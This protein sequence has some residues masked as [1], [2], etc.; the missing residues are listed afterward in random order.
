MSIVQDPEL[1][2]EIASYIR[3]IPDHPK[4]GVRFRDVSTLAGDPNGLKLAIDGICAAFSTDR[5]QRVAG[6]E[7]RGF[8][9]GGAVAVALGTGFTLIRKSGKLPAE[10][11]SVDYELE[12]GSESMEI[13]RDAL[14]PGERVLLIDDLI[15]TGGTILAALDLLEQLRADVVGVATIVDLPELGGSERILARG[16]KVRALTEFAGE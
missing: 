6:I 7:A 15:A 1:S 2:A 4:P 13:H 5:P 16:V 11:L 8:I 12:Y 14:S 10:T 9:P 3:T